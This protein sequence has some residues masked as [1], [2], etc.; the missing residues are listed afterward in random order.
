MVSPRRPLRLRCGLF[1]ATLAMCL[2]LSSCVLEEVPLDNL[3][4]PCAPGWTCSSDLKC[5][6][7]DVLCGRENVEAGSI[8]VTNLR[9]EW[10]TSNQV[11]LR[12]D[13][14]DSSDVF[15]Y[16]VDV[17][18]S[19]ES[20][21]ATTGD[22]SIT[23]EDNPELGRGF[24]PGSDSGDVVD[25]TSVRELEPD[26]GYFFRVVVV[27]NERG[28]SCT[29]VAAART[30]PEARQSAVLF[31][32]EH[33][34]P[35]AGFTTLPECVERREDLAGSLMGNFHYAYQVT[36]VGGIA[37]CPCTNDAGCAAE[38]TCDLGRCLPQETPPEYCY[39]NI[40]LSQL[41][42]ELSI[43]SAG[44]FANAFFEVSVAIDDSPAATWA[45]LGVRTAVG[46]FTLGRNTLVAD[47]TYH[48]YQVPLSAMRMSY[49]DL[50]GRIDELRVGSEFS[51]GATVR[52]DEA[53]IRW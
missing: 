33:P 44:V 3:D 12:W 20:L 42:V 19:A 23:L 30:L 40:R 6:R 22:Y 5:V 14:D 50:G 35:G 36:C 8:G 9:V 10:G 26:Q 49:D 11:R 43:P 1:Y 18:S 52:V 24:L 25:R 7:G 39:E 45:E 32:E 51:D 47:G 15:A 46:V 4:C 21:V 29:E 37:A 38:Q 53:Y 34:N 13:V 41:R 48:T 17:A 2:S 27:D 31:R 16:E 28:V